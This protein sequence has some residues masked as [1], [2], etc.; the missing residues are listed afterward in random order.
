MIIVEVNK[1]KNIETALRTYKNKVQKVKQIQQLR[2][3]Q[4]YTKPSVKRRAQL[5]KAI[6]VEKLRNGLK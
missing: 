5:L 4:T 1:E 6:H 3:K 2:D